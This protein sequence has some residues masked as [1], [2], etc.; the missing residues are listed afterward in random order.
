MGYYVMSVSREIAAAHHNGPPDSKCRVNHGHEWLVKVEIVYGEDALD[1]YNWGVDFGKVKAIIDQYDHQDLNTLMSDPP[2]AEHFARVLA[3]NIKDGTG[4]MPRSIEL[5]E[6]HG[7]IMTY[8]PDA[9][10]LEGFKQMGF[11]LVRDG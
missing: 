7:N 2:S 1:R 4:H 6:G 5:H 3:H 10:P 11:D 8:Y 9:N